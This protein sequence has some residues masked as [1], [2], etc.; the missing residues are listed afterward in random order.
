[1]PI[2]EIFRERTPTRERAGPLE[3]AWSSP[4]P[5]QS[6][7][8]QRNIETHE[9]RVEGVG[10]GHGGRELK[11]RGLHR[12]GAGEAP[13]GDWVQLDAMYDVFANGFAQYRLAR[14][15]GALDR[16]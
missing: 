10:R 14:L 9:K 6:S 8:Y 12:R 1:M 4:R 5:M 15:E 13:Q 16:L 2:W 7:V 11:A 3:L